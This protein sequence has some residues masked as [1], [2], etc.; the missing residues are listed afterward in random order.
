[1]E[2]IAKAGKSQI[3]G[4]EGGLSA[5]TV[6]HHRLLH[7]ALD[8]AVRRQLLSRNPATAV[9]PPRPSRTEMQVLDPAGVARLLEAAEGTRA[10]VPVLL[11]VM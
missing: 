7:E 3:Q 2:L 4:A 1:M 6:L 11:A 9:E 8:Q 5:Q 10:Y